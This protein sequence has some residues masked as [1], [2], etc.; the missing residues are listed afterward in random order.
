MSSNTDSDISS[1]AEWEAQNPAQSFSEREQ[2]LLD[3]KDPARVWGDRDSSND[4]RSSD[5][6]SASNDEGLSGQNGGAVGIGKKGKKSEIPSPTQGTESQLASQY[7]EHYAPPSSQ[8]RPESSTSDD[9]E[10][11]DAQETNELLINNSLLSTITNSPRTAHDLLQLKTSVQDFAVEHPFWTQS[12]LDEEE[13]LEFENDVFEFAKAAGLGVNLAKVEV[14]RALG[15]WKKSK[16]IPVAQAGHIEQI[17]DNVLE[18]IESVTEAI[19]SG[20]KKRKREEKVIAVPTPVPLDTIEGSK[21]V[22]AKEPKAKRQRRRENKRKIVEETA[23][24]VDTAPS[25]PVILDAVDH[26]NSE[27][28][29]SKSQRRREKKK[30]KLEEEGSSAVEA[31]NPVPDIVKPVKKVKKGEAPLDPKNQNVWEGEKKKLDQLVAATAVPVHKSELKS[32]KRIKNEKKKEKKKRAKQGPST[33]SY[34]TKTDVPVSAKVDKDLPMEEKKI[35][36]TQAKTEDVPMEDV[37]EDREASVDKKS[38]GNENLGHSNAA[39][40]E[41]K[42]KRKKKRNKNR[43]SEVETVDSL[44]AAD[45]RAARKLGRSEKP[46]AVTSTTDIS[47]TTEQSGKKKRVRSRIMKADQEATKEVDNATVLKPHTETLPATKEKS[48]DITTFPKVSRLSS[49]DVKISKESPEEKFLVRPVR[50]F[51]ANGIFGAADADSADVPQF[52]IERAAIEPAPAKEKSRKR[53]K[54]SRTEVDVEAEPAT[55]EAPTPE[56][57]EPP[58]KKSRDRKRKSINKL[59]GVQASGVEEPLAEPLVELPDT[60]SEKKKHKRG[61]SKKRSSVS[62]EVDAQASKEASN[63]S[64]S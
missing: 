61:K 12:T 45:K 57:S 23:L 42:K 43:L 34:F 11:E 52:V 49:D 35:V 44:Q 26:T 38:V 27:Q 53:K 8:P 58:K 55:A 64:H 56:D 19:G 7:L 28:A 54:K 31:G 3:M 39:D 30:R 6:E 33:S 25:V 22:E 50:T 36:S 13:A 20:Q 37:S 1:F 46:K 63:S 14:M 21:K 16:G 60:N 32:A 51:N 41:E 48:K 40:K 2:S 29:D 62:T 47:E 24:A 4:A 15:A 10:D 5:E 17:F 18:T 9:E 59:L